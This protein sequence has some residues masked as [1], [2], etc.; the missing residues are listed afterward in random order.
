MT[1]WRVPD[2]LA[3]VFDLDGVIVDSMPMHTE[4]WRTYLERLGIIDS[5][6]ENQMHA[7][8]SAVMR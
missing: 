4:A 8:I 3:L 1:G 5:D 7:A 6:I 2:G